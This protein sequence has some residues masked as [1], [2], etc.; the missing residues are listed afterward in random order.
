[1]PDLD[2][3]EGLT[4]EEPTEEVPREHLTLEEP[5]EPAPVPAAADVQ[6]A[7]SRAHLRSFTTIALGVVLAVAA[8]VA[9]GYAAHR[10][11]YTVGDE[12]APTPPQDRL[13]AS[14]ATV[15]TA[16]DVV[17]PLTDVPG[18]PAI[19]K[20][21]DDVGRKGAVARVVAPLAD[22]PDIRPADKASQDVDRQEAAAGPRSSRLAVADSLLP[23]PSLIPRSLYVPGNENR[24]GS[25]HDRR[26]IRLR[27]LAGAGF[28]A[29]GRQVHRILEVQLR[30]RSQRR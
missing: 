27:L 1:M 7:V 6:P 4:L 3:R 12:A 23:R 28:A 19:D 21:S 26:I 14:D 20:A 17:A 22:V 8:V 5:A 30:R 13:P 18:I 9:A 10:I 15:K 11:H 29:A 16:A 24:E 2:A 25:I